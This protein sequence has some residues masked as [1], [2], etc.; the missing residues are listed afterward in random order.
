MNYGVRDIHRLYKEKSDK[1]VDLRTFKRVWE[2]FIDDA[3][4]NV[5]LEGKDFIMPS[6]GSLGIRKQKVIVAMTPEGDIDK[7]YLRPDWKKTKE[8]W[9]ND[10]EAKENNS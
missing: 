10:A 8:L 4:E 7:R 1:P 5:L 6:L 3:M 2:S 9:E